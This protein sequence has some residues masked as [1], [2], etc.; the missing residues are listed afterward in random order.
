MVHLQAAC[1]SSS[2]APSRMTATRKLDHNPPQWSVNFPFADHL[3]G[4]VDQSLANGRARH[5]IRRAR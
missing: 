1:E 3:D 4:S 5:S 2:G